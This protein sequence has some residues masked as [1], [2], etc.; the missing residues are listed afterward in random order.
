M[1][2]VNLNF[3]YISLSFMSADE[4]IKRQIK[5]TVIMKY[6]LNEF[7]NPVDL[8]EQL[9]D[10]RY[11]YTDSS[12][13]EGTHKFLRITD[14]K[15]GRVD[16]DTVPYCDCVNPTGYLL[17]RGD[18]LVARTGG[19]TGKSFLITETSSPSVFA[20]YLIRLRTSE[21]LN[22]KF[23]DLFLNSFVYWNQIVDLKQGSAQPNVN[24]EKLKGLI[25]PYCE[26]EMQ[27][28]VLQLIDS[29]YKNTN[30]H[31]ELMGVSE[32]IKLIIEKFEETEELKALFNNQNLQATSLRQSILQEAV[33]GKLVPQ[34]PNDEPASVLLERIKAEKAQL[35][36]EKKIKREKRLP[37]ISEEEIPYELPMGWEWVRFA[38]VSCKLGA[39]S[40]PTGG[41]NV[42]SEKGIK[43]IRSQNVWNNG[44]KIDNIAYI[45]DEINNKMQGSIVKANDILLNITGAS[46][47][48]SCIVN[49][50]FDMA[51]VNQH[52]SIIRLIDSNMNSFIHKCII[53]PYIQNLIMN[54][55]VGV[56]REGLSMDKLGRFLI[57]IPP[58]NEQKR[59]AERVDHLMALCDELEKTVEQS[60]RES[61][62]LM[63]AVLQEAFQQT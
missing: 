24:A 47:G 13:E 2:E 11:G 6:V 49:K 32:N 9:V 19:T 63:Q 10:T 15:D 8:V 33:Q 20:S 60:K 34:D 50:D 58:Q 5:N 38:S 52:V 14:I 53:S 62:I 41:K 17:E 18:I 3:N 4:E 12:K 54:V 7:K 51:N 29:K 39:G 36:N 28:K 25:I 59:I 26:I 37:E 57:P 55:Q 44:L 21:N 56:S 22:P 45:S 35:I 16:W 48:R 30:L 40:T 23:L 31:H 27:E 46:I 61:E 1:T 43:F 42:Y